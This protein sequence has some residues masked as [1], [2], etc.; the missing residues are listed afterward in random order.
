MRKGKQK[1]RLSEPN[2]DVNASVDFFK[3]KRTSSYQNSIKH[4]VRHFLQL[5]FGTSKEELQTSNPTAKQLQV[6]SKVPFFL[7]CEK[8]LSIYCEEVRLLKPSQLPSKN[9]RR[10]FNW[11]VQ[12]VSHPN[13]R[14]LVV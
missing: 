11:R 8:N 1:A 10:R 14:Q 7:E 5:S 3:L 6:R 2:N 9:K 13:E 4:Q 12:D